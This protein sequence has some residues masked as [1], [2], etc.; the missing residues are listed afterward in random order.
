[1]IRAIVFDFDGVLV[2]SVEVKTRA[3][4][5]LF[6]GETP[7]AVERIVTYHR[8]HGGISRFEKFETIYRDLLKRP[9]SE[10]I[11]HALCEQFSRLVVEEV[12]AAPWVEGA[13]ELNGVD[14][15]RRLRAAVV[16]QSTVG[17]RIAERGIN[18]Q[19]VCVVRA[20]NR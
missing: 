13:L 5:R 10:E 14:R 7:E 1:M 18:D 12:V 16:E 8:Q 6:A 9:L 3:F 17:N 11:F 4:A 2:E 15:T 20:E 19:C